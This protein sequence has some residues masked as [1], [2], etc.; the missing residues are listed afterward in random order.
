MCRRAAA[1]PSQVSPDLSPIEKIINNIVST[2]HRGS[3]PILSFQWQADKVD[4]LLDQI[5]ARLLQCDEPKVRRFEYDYG[6]NTVYLNIVGESAFQLQVQQGLYERLKDRLAELPTLD[7]IDDPE[8]C[9]LIRSIKSKGT[10][11]V[12]YKSKLCQQPDV[13]FGQKGISVPS[14]VCEV[15]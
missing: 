11:L 2:R 8:V 12:K 13:A 4:E 14:L 10:A 6:S 5:Q 9:R 7:G 3:E 15:S 1:D